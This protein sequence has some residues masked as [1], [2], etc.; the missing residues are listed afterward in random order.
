MH[1]VIPNSKKWIY[2]S[3]NPGASNASPFDPLSRGIID[4]VQGTKDRFF[5]SFQMV[6]NLSDN[7]AKYPSCL[8]ET[9]NY[10]LKNKPDCKVLLFIDQFEELFTHFDVF[11]IRAFV[12]MVVRSV[13][14]ARIKIII[15][16]R[17]DFYK[18][19]L[20]FAEFAKLLQSNSFPLSTPKLRNLYEM[21]INPAQIAGLEFEIGLTGRRLED[22]KSEPGSLALLA[23]GLYQL[24]EE[25][26][27]FA[28]LSNDAY[29]RFGGITGAIGIQATKAFDELED[30][31]KLCF[32]KVFRELVDVDERGLPTKRRLELLSVEL[33]SPEM[34]LVSKLTEHRLLVQTQN[35]QGNAVIEIAHEALF[36]SWSQL[37]EWIDQRNDDLKFGGELI[38]LAIRWKNNN[39][40]DAYLLPVI[41]LGKAS[42]WKA[43]A[44][45]KQILRAEQEE[46]IISSIAHH[47]KQE[48]RSKRNRSMVIISLV[49]I[50]VLFAGFSI[51]SGFLASQRNKVIKEKEMELVRSL[52]NKSSYLASLSSKEL[53]SGSPQNA[54]ILA[55]ESLQHFEEGIWNADGIDALRNSLGSPVQEISYLL[56]GEIDP[57]PK[58]NVIWD[59]GIAK[60]MTFHDNRLSIWDISGS[61]KIMN[62]Y[63]Q[64]SLSDATWLADGDKIVS[65]DL[66]IAE[67]AITNFGNI[68][69]WNA[70]TGEKIY[71]KHFTEGPFT[72]KI[73]SKQN[74]AAAQ[75]NNSILI[76]NLDSGEEKIE[77]PIESWIQD[78]EWSSDDSFILG[79]SSSQY[80][81]TCIK[82]C[83]STITIWDIHSGQSVF[84]MELENADLVDVYF[85]DKNTPLILSYQSHNCGENCIGFMRSYDFNNDKSIMFGNSS[86]VVSISDIKWNRKHSKFII[87]GGDGSAG[88]IDIVNKNEP[89]NLSHDGYQINGAIWNSSGDR[90]LSWGSDGSIREWD[91]L[92]GKQLLILRHDGVVNGAAWNKDEQLIYSWS[93]DRNFRIWNR[94]NGKI[95]ATLNHDLG[96]E[97]LMEC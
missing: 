9:I 71:S 16:L 49:F 44:I 47:K 93:D 32:S 21:I 85:I 66:Y 76:L 30:E 70:S 45:E 62:L 55:L 95:V 83:G 97:S 88:I 68:Y 27:P 12:N 90:V 61:N 24:Y 50:S 5:N 84:S 78:I 36:D 34:K 31:A 37:K 40:N 23:F 26:K 92:T 64:T 46:Y 74:F 11:E 80:D 77:I 22:T 63:H 60:A 65:W 33:E 10:E 86:D 94:S 69:L 15:S 3:I 18:Y 51:L 96:V 52:K 19:C 6:T 2:I 7:L 38:R 13:K 1:N 54:L 25:S 59:D 75:T 53:L 87:R 28:L 35:D 39:K 72:V 57:F 79:W 56:P 67:D 14:S 29:D 82:D 41:D 91:A 89:I 17:V 4:K 20:K 58:P 73:D 42:A 43:R 48:K 8:E 81:E